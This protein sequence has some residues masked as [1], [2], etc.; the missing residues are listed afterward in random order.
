MGRKVKGYEEWGREAKSKGRRKED[1]REEEREG[2]WLRYTEMRGVDEEVRRIIDR[3][4]G[5]K[6]RIKIGS[7]ITNVKQTILEI[8]SIDK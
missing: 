2:G 8:S 6:E 5:K 7:E 3:N 4:K 1:E